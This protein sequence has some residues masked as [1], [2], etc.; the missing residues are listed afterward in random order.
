MFAHQNR[1][2]N[3]TNLRLP[4]NLYCVGGDVKHCTMLIHLG[5][6]RIVS[7]RIAKSTVS[8]ADADCVI[9]T[10]NDNRQFLTGLLVKAGVFNT[11]AIKNR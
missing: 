2:L 1:Y 3:S 5:S 8:P 9:S 11:C 7:Y 10:T 6:Y 4:Y